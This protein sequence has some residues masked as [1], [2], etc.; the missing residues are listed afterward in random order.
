MRV[1]VPIN[2]L[3]AREEDN[4]KRFR[5]HVAM[6]ALLRSDDGSVLKKLSRDVILEGALES[7]QQARK[8]VYKFQEQFLVSASKYRID[9]AIE[10]RN[11]DKLSTKTV[12]S[13]KPEIDEGNW[14]ESREEQPEAAPETGSVTRQPQPDAKLEEKEG[15]EDSEPTIHLVASPQLLP[16]AIRPSDAELS[17]ILDGARQRISDY[18]RRLPNFVCLMATKRF[19]D[20]SGKGPWKLTDSY[21]S[22]LRYNGEDETTALLDV[23][24][25]RVGRGD[26]D[27][28]DG[29]S[30]RGEFGETLSMIF[31][32]RAHAQIDWVGMAPVLGAR[33]HVFRCTGAARN[34]EYRVVA[35]RNLWL[36]AAYHAFV[37]IDAG[38][39]SVRRLTIA[40]DDIPSTFPIKESGLSID[41]DYIPIA[42]QEYL[43][44][45]QATLL[46]RIGRH[47]SRKNEISFQKY[48]KYTAQSRMR[49][50]SGKSY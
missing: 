35:N 1:A 8:Q 11:A 5:L 31:S 43:L 7:L 24:G 15:F 33:T 48:R 37:Y 29:A 12:D 49:F 18:K 23:N 10:D 19:A 4:T 34:S 6:L 27:G 25:K 40:A 39:L 45:V 36:H 44:P 30:V 14:S 22:A 13:T 28:F 46:V 50:E 20:S 17:S 21:T 3:V 41:Y 2:G 47:D 26:Q 32:D 9:I 42:G 38:T 16:N